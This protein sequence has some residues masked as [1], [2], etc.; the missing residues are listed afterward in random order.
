MYY[1]Y[2][3][4]GIKIG[5]SEEPAIRVAKQGYTSYTILE[6]HT[7]IYVASRREH[8][9]QKE[10]GYPVDDSPYW[11]SRQRWGANAGKIGGRKAVESGQLYSICALGGS[12]AGK[13][14]RAL[15]FDQ[16]E[17][18]RQLFLSG[19]YTRKDLA[20]MYSVTYVIIKTIINNSR[21]KER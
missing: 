1:I 19:N 15:T 10:Y 18:I 11:N 14:K 8:E 9:L 20:S 13:K 2:H 4:P 16:A 12:S 6:E 21:Y 7:D 5:C 3:I 17:E